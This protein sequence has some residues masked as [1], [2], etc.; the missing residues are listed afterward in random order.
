[1]TCV[2]KGKLYIDQFVLSVYVSVNI[3]QHLILK[4]QVNIKGGHLKNVVYKPASGSPA[5]TT[6]LFPV[7]ERFLPHICLKIIASTNLV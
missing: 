5:N 4:L 3:S 7:T 2:C 1:M 6:S